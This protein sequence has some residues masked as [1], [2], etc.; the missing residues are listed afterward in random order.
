MKIVNDRHDAQWQ[1]TFS[2][3]ERM[4][5]AQSWLK[6]D[7]L[8][9]LYNDLIRNGVEAHAPICIRCCWERVPNWVS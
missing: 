2:D 5:V 1:K 3:P 7:N 6:D 4:A 8:G 9:F